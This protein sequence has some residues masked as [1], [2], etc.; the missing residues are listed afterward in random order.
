MEA[1]YMI[2]CKKNS[3]KFDADYLISELSIKN[4]DIDCDAI[5]RNQLIAGLITNYDKV[6]LQRNF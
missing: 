6:F 3:T 2:T 1:H 5:V 4:R